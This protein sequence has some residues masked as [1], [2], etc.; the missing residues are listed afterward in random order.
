MILRLV[1]AIML[2]GAVGSAFAQDKPPEAPQAKQQEKAPEKESRREP[3]QNILRLLPADSVTEHSIAT[4]QGKLAYT[5]TAGT[6]A[7]F[8]QS[9]NQSASVFYTAYT[10][11]GAN[12]PLTFAF[13]GGPG[14]ASA[15]LH[16]GLVGPRILDLGPDGH[17]AA[18]AAL[19]DNPETWLRFT[20]LV[21]IDPIGTGWSRAASDAKGFWSVQSDASAMAKA[22]SLYVT[23]NNR[24]GAQKFLLGESYGGLRAVKTARALLRD[25][26]VAVSGIVMLS[27]L[28]EGWLTFGDARGTA[29]AVAGGGRTRT[30]KDLHARGAARG[31][32]IRHERIPGDAGGA[33]AAGR[34]RQVLL[35]ARRANDRPVRGQHRAV[36]R[37]R[38]RLHQ[39]PARRQDRQPL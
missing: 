37:L 4:A 30:Q 5:A 29:T 14:A 18:R 13:N 39:E 19:H 7:F 9:G 22:I 11:K 1:T 34:R 20:D 35:S 36:A 21:L 38:E 8:D 25:Q 3:A 27:P 10:V 16:L 23:H 26:G 33:A 31:G 15:Y 17:D 28:L 6:L 12:R 2:A 32:E 24:S